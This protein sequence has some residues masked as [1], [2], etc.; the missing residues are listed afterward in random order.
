MD[1]KVCEKSAIWHKRKYG[2]FKF[3]AVETAPS[4]NTKSA[5][6]DFKYYGMSTHIIGLVI[7][8]G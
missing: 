8:K 7:L 6:A 3:P 1:T 4:E 5:F 2:M